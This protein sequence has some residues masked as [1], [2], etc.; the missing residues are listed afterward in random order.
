MRYDLSE[1]LR[2]YSSKE[3]IAADVAEELGKELKRFLILCAIFP[4]KQYPMTRVVDPLWHEF[5]MFTR[6]YSEYC[7]LLAGHF[8]HHHPNTEDDEP[9]DSILIR[10]DEFFID[11]KSVFGEETPAAYWPRLRHSEAPADCTNCQSKCH[12]NDCSRCSGPECDRR[13]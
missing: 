5:I 12:A 7:N 9:R 3:H 10:F 11:Y 2:R 6:K 4:N 1:V 13:P 8:I